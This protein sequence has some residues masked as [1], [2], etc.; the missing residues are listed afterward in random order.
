MRVG[1]GVGVKVARL[2]QQKSHSE[3]ESREMLQETGFRVCWMRRI[4]WAFNILKQIIEK[5]IFSV[6][7]CLIYEN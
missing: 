4:C 6:I 1:V 5:I 2:I 7:S 3:S